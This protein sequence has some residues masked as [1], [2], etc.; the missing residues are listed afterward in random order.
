MSP[1]AT[2]SLA[3]AARSRKHSPFPHIFAL[4][5]TL[6]A[7]H[8]QLQETGPPPS[9]VE[10]GIIEALRPGGAEV[11]TQPLSA[12]PATPL[13]SAGS[14]GESISAPSGVTSIGGT[15]FDDL[16]VDVGRPRDRLSPQTLPESPLEFELNSSIEYND[17]I[18]IDAEDEVSD[19]VF[20]ISPTLR[21]SGGDYQKRQ[22]AFLTAAYT[23]TGTVYVDD[24][25]DETLD[26]LV[27]LIGQWR[28]NKLSVPVR[29]N[30]SRRT[31]AF[32]DI[33]DRDT[34][35]AYSLGGGLDYQI[36]SKL[37]A[38]FL[39]DYFARDYERF[40]DSDTTLVDAYINYRISDKTETGLIFRY[41]DSGIDGAASQKY[42]AGLARVRYLPSNKLR[43]EAEVGAAFSDL[44]RGN[45]ADL[46]YRLA[47]IYQPSARRRFA[48]E[49]RRQPSTS[50]FT[51]G[52]GFINNGLQ[53][54]YTQ[55]IAN[56]LRLQLTGGYQ[57]QDYFS[58][59]EGV[60]ID[61]KDDYFLLSS[62]LSYQINRDLS[63]NFYYSFINNDSTDPLVEF[64][65][66]RAG[67]GLNWTY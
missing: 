7:A 23:A 19:A 17:N 31:S 28:H 32:V 41:S 67:V 37:S 38:G 63:A 40:A 13:G 50:S 27:E 60:T 47:A 25:A 18:F 6:E 66:Q 30:F 46:I 39:V 16:A 10:S 33:G 2:P 61:R 3:L 15:L 14:V 9:L 21:L 12:S 54:S 53:L 58:A 57:V 59:D 44:Q 34:A 51:I 43:L 4:L 29:A 11:T 49:A 1:L 5:L 52:S 65:N 26:H 8:A 22:A 42:Q 24:T 48:L 45:R 62:L 56:K 64:D 20:V 35:T 36:S 55:A